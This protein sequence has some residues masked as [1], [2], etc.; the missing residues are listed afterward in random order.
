MAKGN[1][2]PSRSRQAVAKRDR[3]ICII[4]GMN[5]TDLHHRQRRR[6]GGHGVENLIRLCRTDHDTVHANPEESRRNG[7]IVSA[8][9]D[10]RPAEIP[11]KTY[12]G[13]IMLNTDGTV[14]YLNGAING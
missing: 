2:I 9:G 4:C 6:T 8:H 3:G 13:L 14:T 1:A 5:G 10:A 7:W 11:I 12:M